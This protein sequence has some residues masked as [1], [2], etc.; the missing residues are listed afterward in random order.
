MEYLTL[1]E[2]STFTGGKVSPKFENILIKSVSTDSREIENDALFVPIRGET[3]DGHDFIADC[4]NKGAAG[5]LS[6]KPQNDD[7]PCVLV[8]DTK[9]VLRDLA[10]GYL[11]RFNIPKCAVT[12]SVG[13]T[14]TKD[15]IASVLSKRF[16]TV[17]TEGN[18]NNEIGL[19]RTVFGIDDKTEAAVLEMGM[20]H[21]GEISRLS[22][23]VRPNICVITNIGVSHIENLGSREGILRAKLEITD[24]MADEGVLILNGDDEYLRNAVTDRG[25]IFFGIDNPAD[26]YADNISFDGLEATLADIHKGD[27]HFTVRIPIPGKH[28]VINALAAAAVGFWLGLSP[29]EIKSGIEDFKQSKMR[30]D[31]ISKN[32]INIINDVYNANPVSVKASLDV[33]KSASGRRAAILGDMFELGEFSPSMHRDVGNYAASCGID[34]LIAIGKNAKYIFEGAKEKGMTN[35][36][37][38]ETQE[39]FFEK[40]MDKIMK[41]DTVLV[42]ASR[43]MHLEKTVERLQEVD[44]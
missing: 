16:K 6:E 15:M 38:Y 41:G 30:M 25:T 44:L 3:F 21:F 10:E 2:V 9:K 34:V 37:L 27:V 14:T 26:I 39:E 5:V 36:F 18:F 35:C 28:M 17:K 32:S 4:I 1:K 12:G 24:Y 43:G 29:E 40:G 19:P 8:E 33:L 11:A 20:N 42:K 23:I 31:I 13:K 22:K 7:V